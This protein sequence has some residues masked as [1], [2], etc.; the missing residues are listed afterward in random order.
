LTIS[1]VSALA[2]NTYLKFSLNGAEPKDGFSK[3]IIANPNPM[4]YNEPGKSPNI[5][6]VEENSASKI[7]S[8]EVLAYS[9]V[10]VKFPVNLVPL[11]VKSYNNKQFK[12]KQNYPNPFNE[13]TAI[14]FELDKISHV[15][16]SVFD[17]TGR[18]VV[19]LVNSQMD[20]G[21][22]SETWYSSRTSNGIYYC[23]LT[24]DNISLTNKMVL[25]H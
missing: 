24:V 15:K 23:T 19:N 21:L 17:I 4:A 14:D 12:L 25:I 20:P 18:E 22:Y 7:D 3:W 6:I 5:T 8:I 2:T 11:G 10:M 9:I 13:K 16:L 1:V